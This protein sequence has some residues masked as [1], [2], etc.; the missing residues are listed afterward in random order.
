MDKIN[1]LFSKIERMR[2]RTLFA[3][4]GLL[5]FLLV[6]LWIA[7]GWS[8][9]A[10]Y[11]ALRQAKFPRGGSVLGL[12]EAIRGSARIS[13][14]PE[15]RDLA[16]QAD[17]GLTERK[18]VKNGTLELLVEK[19]EKAADRIQTIALQAGGFVDNL[20]LRE[21]ADGV[22]SGSVTVRVPAARF[23]EVV[24]EVKRLAIKVESERTATTDVTERFVDIEARL[25]NAKAEETQYLNIMKE[26][27]TVEDTLKV[28]ERLA[29]V[30]ERIERLEAQLKILKQQI[31]MSS[32]VVS[33]TSEAEIEVLG[34][35]WRPLLVA[36]KSLKSL[37]AG[38]TRY[39]DFMIG[40]IFML[41]VIALWL[42]T[43]IGILAL[44]WRVLKWFKK[45]FHGKSSS[46]ISR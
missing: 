26:A 13:P 43:A 9:I 46:K 41:P 38:F 15:R 20:F 39:V 24:N 28:A 30:R 23:D 10:P 35:H 19:A 2:W 21:V 27:D 45:F 11:G 22:V 29:G 17:A 7:Q 1:A 33:L 44:A 6:A 37:L 42:A 12:E 31:K 25:V 40:F 8:I 5:V 16:P 3:I 14:A 34:I 18:I 4:G 32:L 36:K